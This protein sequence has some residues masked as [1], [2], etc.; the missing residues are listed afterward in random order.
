MVQLDVREKA[1]V[2]VIMAA[3][4]PLLIYCLHLSEGERRQVTAI[5]QAYTRG[6]GERLGRLLEQEK[7]LND[8]TWAYQ[9]GFTRRLNDFLTEEDSLPDTV[10]LQVMIQTSSIL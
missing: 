4:T 7:K 1:N 9:M 2:R 8:H 6:F 10:A 5:V 3:N